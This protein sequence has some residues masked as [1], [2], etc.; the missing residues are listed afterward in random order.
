MASIAEFSPI[1]Q[2]PWT[3]ILPGKRLDRLG[4]GPEMLS[5][6]LRSI[7]KLVQVSRGWHAGRLDPRSQCRASRHASLR[8]PGCRRL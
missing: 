8:S 2:V 3:N 4:S 7:G 1:P 5:E 6:T